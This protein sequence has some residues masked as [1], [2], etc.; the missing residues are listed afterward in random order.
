V[1]A[2]RDSKSKPKRGEGPKI[3]LPKETVRDLNVPESG[4]VKG[5]ATP[6]KG[7]SKNSV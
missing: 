7:C 5:G 2:K 3:V 1:T 4:Q 6:P